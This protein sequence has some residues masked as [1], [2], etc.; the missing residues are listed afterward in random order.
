M[1]HQLDLAY[2]TPDECQLDLHLPDPDHFPLFVYFHGGG[3]EKGD[4]AQNMAFIHYLNAQ[5]IAVASVN[6]RMYPNAHYPDFLED[7]A[8][9]VAWIWEKFSC[10]VRCDGIWIGGSSAGGYLSMMLCFDSSLLAAHRLKPTDFRGFF[11]DAGQPTAHFRVLRERGIDSRRIIVDESAPLY[12]IGTVPDYPPMR[13]VIS[14]NDM[15]GRYEQTRLAVAA[16]AHFGFGSDKVS[17][18]KMHGKHCA[19]VKEARFG[20]M[21][22]D[23]IRNCP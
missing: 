19:Y 23:F 20:Q 13:F 12:H 22:A 4:K 11:H 2:R 3:L 10:D 6:Y 18:V 15:F 16:L 14:D 9:A 21:I 1:T 5:G 17:L 8:A 7:A